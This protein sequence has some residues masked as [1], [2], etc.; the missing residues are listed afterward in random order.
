MYPIARFVTTV[1]S[2]LLAPRVGFLDT[3][4]ITLPVRRGD[5]EAT[6]MNNGRYLTLMD[7][8]RFALTLRAGYLP[9]V[10]KRRWTPVVG[11]VLIQFK[12]S[13]RI[14][15]AF[16]LSTRVACWDDKAFFFEQWFEQQGELRAR[17]LVRALFLGP[18]G[19]I[20]S[21]E[22]VNAGGFDITSPP[23]AEGVRAWRAAEGAA[24]GGVSA[25]N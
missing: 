9:I 2:A 24:F 12:R 21:A 10:A 15:T 8:G 22:V 5:V 1:T 18:R 4:T 11:G 7:L 19:A 16:E 3:V 14:G 25:G 6:F 20:P 13:L 23:L 17:A